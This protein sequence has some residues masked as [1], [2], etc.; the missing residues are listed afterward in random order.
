MTVHLSEHFSYKNLFKAVLPS[1]FMMIFTSIYSIVDGLFV[2]NFVGKTA[3]AAIN[4]VF[5]FIMIL[6]AIG[7]M[8]GAGGSALVAKTLGEGDREK[9]NRI[10]SMIVYFNIIIGVILSVAGFFLIEPV[11]KAM[12][13]TPEMLPD[14]ARYGKILV[15][16][17]FVFMLQ[18]I[19]QSFFV[20]A[21]KPMLGFLIIVLAGV[22][23]MILDAVF[24]IGLKMGIEGAA[25][26][27][28]I[29]YFV[30]GVV[31]LIYFARNNKSLLRFV[32]T[33]FEVKPIWKSVLNGSSELLTNVSASIVGILFNMQL[34][35]IAGENGVAAYGVIMYA[36]FIFAAIFLGYSIGIAPIVGYNFG[37]KNHSEL[38]NL[39]KK[40][41]III[42]ITG[43]IMTFLTETLAMPLS[44]IFVGYDNELLIM[45]THGMR[46]FSIGFLVCGINIFASSFFTSLNNGLISAI[47]S[48]ARTL[49]FQVVCVMVLPIWFGLDG[50]WV[51]VVVSELLAVIISIICFVCCRKKYQY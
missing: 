46:L 35:K 40:S 26:A 27:T 5:P 4:F 43:L 44:K 29:S 3:F 47:I 6:G 8:F 28:S 38:K 2:S 31:P 22:T 14:C 37:A 20:V 9:A 32:K 41:L 10:F 11:A 12:G 18:N 19:F 1:I 50:I 45:T 42:C 49:L 39:L 7:F 25:V 13:A 51:S 17:V 48:F 30:G 21:E 24:I 23:N 33:K 34:L 16:F 36:S 15:S